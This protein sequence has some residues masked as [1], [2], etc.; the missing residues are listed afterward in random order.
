MDLNMDKV[1][2]ILEIK[3]LI[4]ASM[5]MDYLKDMANIFGVIKAII[6]EIL[7]RD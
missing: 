6:R 3:I 7:N 1:L 2:N 5:S 4:K